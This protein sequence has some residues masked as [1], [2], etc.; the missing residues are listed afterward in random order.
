MAIALPKILL[1]RGDLVVWVWTLGAQRSHQLTNSQPFQSE[2]L[3]LEIIGMV[4]PP[5]SL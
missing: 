2:Q 5:L 1:E 3:K 4:N